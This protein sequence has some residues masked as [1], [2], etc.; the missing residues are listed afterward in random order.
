MLLLKK[1]FTRSLRNQIF[2]T[3]V[4][5]V[6]LFSAAIWLISW[7]GTELAADSFINNKLSQAMAQQIELSLSQGAIIHIDDGVWQSYLSTDKQLPPFL[8]ALNQAGVHEFESLNVHVAM[9]PS[10]YAS[11][12]DVW[13]YLLYY[14]DRDPNRVNYG[15]RVQQF[16]LYLVLLMFAVGVVIAH[17][18]ARL[19]SR[20]ILLLQQQVSAAT[21]NKPPP[22]MV[23]DDEIGQLSLRF[24]SAFERLSWFIVREQNLTRYAS[25]ELRTPITVIQGA[26]DVM[27]YAPNLTA[28]QP[29]IQRIEKANQNMAALVATFL[30][31]GREAVGDNLTSQSL[32]LC[33]EECLQHQAYLL[34]ERNVD[35]SMDINLS[36]HNVVSVYAKV[37]INNLLRN[38]YSYCEQSVRVALQGQRLLIT[39]DVANEPNAGFGHGKHIVA[40]I[41]HKVGWLQYQRQVGEQY[42]WLVYF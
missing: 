26:L 6:S 21:P 27:H 3:L 20:P 37:I 2:A 13:F 10:P 23:R 25:H 24:V 32:V 5:L 16:V 22:L 1:W 42:Y 12:T 34:Q 11:Q 9:Q 40:D 17:Q 35:L 8:A 38:A 7:A 15:A 28:A 29:A 30:S 41:C 33:L 4:F 39:N 18:L 36:N 19:V 14:P 31:L